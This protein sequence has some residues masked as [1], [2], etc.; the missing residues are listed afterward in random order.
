ML[1]FSRQNTLVGGHSIWG[2]LPNPG[3]LTDLFPV[4]QLDSFTIA[5]PGDDFR[6]GFFST[7]QGEG[8]RVLEHLNC[9]L[10]WLL[11]GE[12]I[13]SNISEYL[14]IPAHGVCGQHSISF[15]HLV[16]AQYLQNSS[17]ISFRI[18]YIVSGGTKGPWL[19]LMA[20]LLLFYLLNCFL[21]VSGFSH[22]SQLKLY[23]RLRE[24]GNLKFSTG[25]RRR[26][27]GSVCPR[28]RLCSVLFSS[29][30]SSSYL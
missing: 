25:K 16:G 24:H 1:G 17:R 5:P 11:I 3:I 29:L 26:L 30:S 28:E 4:R 21:F 27:S 22:F 2:D 19:C 23:Q 14:L 9:I 15:F 10:L 13:R 20:K 12:V 7:G 18:L 8:L 6:D